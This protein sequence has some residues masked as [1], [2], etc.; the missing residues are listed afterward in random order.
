MKKWFSQTIKEGEHKKNN[1]YDVTIAEARH[2][3]IFV[4]AV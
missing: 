1:F 3:Y 4:C 2:K